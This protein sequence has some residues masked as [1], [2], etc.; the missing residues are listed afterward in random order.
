MVDAKSLK[1]GGVEVL[2]RHRIDERVAALRVRLANDTAGGHPTTSDDSGESA[3]PVVAAVEWVNPRC[4]TKL[5]DAEHER[6]GLQVTFTEV[7]EQGGHCWVEHAD[8]PIVNR[9]VGCMAIEVFKRHLDRAH[10][11]LHQPPGHEAA[12]AEVA[13]A[14]SIADRLRFVIDLKR[15]EVLGVHQ[16]KGVGNR[17]GVPCS[18]GLSFAAAAKGLRENFESSQTLG[19]AGVFYGRMQVVHAGSRAG[20]P[21]GVKL[22][23]EIATSARPTG[24]PDGDIRRHPQLLTNRLAIELHR[25]HRTDGWMLHGRVWAVA[26]LHEVGAP[27]VIAFFAG[28]RANEG[29]AIHPFGH[30]REK[31]GDLQSRD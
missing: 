4:A 31:A 3:R 15:L 9:E 20:E 5:A 12:A 26:R 19:L 28:E 2:H 21:E 29:H 27:L 16:R 6:G 30:L 17:F 24:I 25:D 7:V 22:A 11:D 18:S 10:T 14:I 1:D 13:V 8:K 23:A